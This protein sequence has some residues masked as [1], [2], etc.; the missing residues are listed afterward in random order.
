MNN[1]A[2]QVAYLATS[3]EFP[4]EGRE[5]TVHLNKSYSDIANAVNA[6]TIGIF[7]TNRSA[8]TGESWFIFQNKRQQSLRQVYTFT[9]T[10]N[11]PH[12]LSLERIDYFTRNFGEFTDGTNWYGIIHG[13]D[14]II[15]GQLS[16]YVSPTQIVFVNAGG[17][18][19]P[20]LTKGIIVLEWISVP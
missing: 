9:S 8:I 1:I 11:I 14:Q 2:N 18:A 7:P 19:V 15:P 20:I 3:R 17:V 6:R 12:G 5:L 10:A 4:E 13:T 16:F